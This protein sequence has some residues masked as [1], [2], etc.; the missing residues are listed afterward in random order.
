VQRRWIAFEQEHQYLAASA[1]RFL[2]KDVSTEDALSLY[3]SLIK[4]EDTVHIETEAITVE[5]QEIV[6][7]VEETIETSSN[8]THEIETTLQPSLF[9]VY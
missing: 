8:E 3:E 1:F 7:I 4:F 5:T 9:E 2:D 6:P